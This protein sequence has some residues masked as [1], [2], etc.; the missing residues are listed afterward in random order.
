[1]IGRNKHHGNQ[2][3]S[4]YLSFD[5][6]HQGTGWQCDDYR[7]VEANNV[8]DRALRARR[9]PSEGGDLLLPAAR[10]A[11]VLGFS[12]GSAMRG[13]TGRYQVR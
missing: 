3:T 5:L 9:A 1:V 8:A 13:R 12:G 6:S 7:V 11:E 2:P 4:H 10:V